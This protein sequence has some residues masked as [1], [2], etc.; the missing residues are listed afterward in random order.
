VIASLVALLVVGVR[1]QVIK[2]TVNPAVLLGVQKVGAQLAVLIEEAEVEVQ[3]AVTKVEA[4]LQ[5][6]LEAIKVEVQVLPGAIK[7]DPLLQAL[8]DQVGAV[9]AVL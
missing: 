5:V 8:N 2:V 7:V 4:L 1:L 6:L 9:V 3:L